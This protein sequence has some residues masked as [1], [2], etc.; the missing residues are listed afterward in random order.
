M[1][2]FYSIISLNSFIVKL[3]HGHF[4]V[5]IDVKMYL[6]SL[7]KNSK[8]FRPEPTYFSQRVVHEVADVVVWPCYVISGVQ[9]NM[10]IEF[11]FAVTRFKF[12][13]NKAVIYVPFMKA[14]YTVLHNVQLL[15]AISNQVK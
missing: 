5:H 7:E 1:F 15:V 11:F 14:S 13:F 9:L 10:A 4:S 12:I 8:L 6:V 3:Q 2:Y